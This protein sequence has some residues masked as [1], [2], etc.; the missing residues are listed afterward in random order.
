MFG[1]DF[2][3]IMVI[4]IVALIVIGPERLPK[5]ARTMGEWWG[6]LQRY[7]N[8]IKADV[9]TSMELEELR[10][11]ERKIKAE[12]DALERTVQQASNNINQEARKLEKEI[13][14]PTPVSSNPTPPAEPPLPP[15]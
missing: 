10:E 14:P 11:L 1:V 4:M 3:E 15:R 6:R 7:I 2:S 8:R 13:E 12:A 5:V 9:T